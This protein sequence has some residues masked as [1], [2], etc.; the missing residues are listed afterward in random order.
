MRGTILVL[1]LEAVPY[2]A[3]AVLQ[4]GSNSVMKGLPARLI[5]E[6]SLRTNGVTK[7]DGIRHFGLRLSSRDFICPFLVRPECVIQ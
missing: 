7:I 3:T 1:P 2:A 4:G 5:L 6:C